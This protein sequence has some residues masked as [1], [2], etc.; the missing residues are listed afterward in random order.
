MRKNCGCNDYH[1]DSFKLR[2][3]HDQDPD[4]EELEETETLKVRLIIEFN[5]GFSAQAFIAGSNGKNWQGFKI[6]A[7]IFERKQNNMAST[8]VNEDDN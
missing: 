8:L 7:K 4:S 5:A 1:F 6:E 3:S 2:P